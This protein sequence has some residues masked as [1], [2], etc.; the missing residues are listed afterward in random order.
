MI[1]SQVLYFCLFFLIA[2]CGVPEVSESA[3]ESANGS[4]PPRALYDII[5][6]NDEAFFEI[7]D[8]VFKPKQ[9]YAEFCDEFNLSKDNKK[10][11]Q[12]TF[13]FTT[14]DKTDKVKLS[15]PFAWF[16]SSSKLCLPFSSQH[17]LCTEQE[18]RFKQIVES[19]EKP[20]VF[21]LTPI[22]SAQVSH[23]NTYLI[24]ISPT[25]VFQKEHMAT[26]IQSGLIEFFTNYKNVYADKNIPA[27]NFRLMKSVSG[28]IISKEILNKEKLL[29]KNSTEV[30]SFIRKEFQ[31]SVIDWRPVRD[32]ALVESQIENDKSIKAILYITDNDG[33]NNFDTIPRN[34]CIPLAWK[35][36][37]INLWIITNENCSV[38]EKQLKVQ[39][40]LELNKDKEDKEGR[41]SKQEED[42]VSD[43]F[44]R[45]MNDFFSN[46]PAK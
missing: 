18:I 45:F 36:D 19:K 10:E 2:G 23:R 33:F 26:I 6:K 30:I 43:D 16:K 39:H 46:Q 31:F 7:S 25:S 22:P 11:K 32:L 8:G 21:K 24:V 38:W 5:S 14:G 9:K 3:S 27:P 15:I 13:Y 34:Q 4:F 1:R 44:K 29:S 41:F 35:R 17:K 12:I 28:R 40:C 42:K 20:L 37:D